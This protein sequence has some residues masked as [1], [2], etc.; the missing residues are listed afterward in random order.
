MSVSQLEEQ[1]RILSKTAGSL[2][3]MTSALL[4][5][6]AQLKGRL[7]SHSERIKNLE[8]PNDKSKQSP[9]NQ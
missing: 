6:L 8:K 3:I 5:D 4:R 7:E 1:M 2:E 9:R